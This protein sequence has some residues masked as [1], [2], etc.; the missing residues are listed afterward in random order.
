MTMT[1]PTV[2]CIDDRPQVL[3]LRKAALESHGYRVKIASSSYTAMKMLDE[4]SLAAVLLEYKEEGMDVE[5]AA[6]R[7]KQRFPNVPIILISAY[8]EMPERVLWLVDRIRDEERTAGT[9]GANYRTHP[10]SSRPGAPP[11]ASVADRRQNTRVGTGAA[12][13]PCGPAVS[14]RSGFGGR[15]GKGTNSSPP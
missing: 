7:I 11:T 12:A 1:S 8:S 5:A 3:E 15:H 10:P 9:P 14:G 4:T 13:R 2:L 6:C